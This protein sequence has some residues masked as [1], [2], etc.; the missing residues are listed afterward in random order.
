MDEH[1]LAKV[2]DDKGRLIVVEPM[3]DSGVAS[4]AIAIRFHMAP[5][6]AVQGLECLA[7]WEPAHA[8]DRRNDHRTLSGGLA[9]SSESLPVVS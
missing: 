8:E 1:I 9:S 3:I 7:V 6:L 5:R 4:R 2:A